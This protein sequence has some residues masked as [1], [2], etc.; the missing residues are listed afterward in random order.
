MF[1]L[2]IFLFQRAF[3]INFF[4]D[5]Y[6]FLKISRASSLNDFVNFFS[7]V[8]GYSYK[9]MATELFYF[10][11]ISLKYR[12]F[13]GHIIVFAVY[14]IGLYYLYRLVRQL[15]KNQ[16]L[17]YLSVFIYGINFIHVYQLYWFATFQ[18]IMV[19]TALTVAFYYFL[20]RKYFLSFIP[21]V[22]ALLSKETAILFVPFLFLFTAVF[23][24][25]DLRKKT[26][27][28][29][30][31]LTIA[32]LFYFVY[33]YSLKQVTALD[34]YKI[35]FDNPK[36]VLNNFLWY[37]LWGLGMPSFMPDVMP[38]IFSKPLPAFNDYFKSQQIQIYF[39]LLGLYWCAVAGMWIYLVVKDRTKL[40]KTL[41]LALGTFAG[42]VIFL[43]PMIFFRH[44]WMIRLTVPL[45]F[46]SL[47]QAYILSFFHNRKLRKILVHVLVVY[48]VLSYFG[49]KIHEST[50]TYLL[51]DNI[52]IKT[53]DYF[54]DNKTRF[55]R[56]PIIYF[57]DSLQDKINPWGGSKKLK[58]SYWDQYFLD[59]YFPGK[60]IRAIYA[61]EQ[62]EPIPQKEC[63]IE[64]DYLLR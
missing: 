14:F 52:F 64:A 16:L 10:L 26:A 59:F 33:R 37:F 2:I 58:N 46:L 60:R 61:F 24:K 57:N 38:S 35:Q 50:S 47:F 23:Q 20:N 15:T 63:I 55:A 13:I 4:L 25:K 11:L 7:P 39:F 9:P 36:L 18:E 1:F 8:R 32:V 5:D 42:F 12:V 27:V 51:E 28:L 54:S 34:N 3:K 31:Y 40:K 41:F 49:I 44:R 19:F 30:F 62:A 56:C 45:V 21:F 17:G 22:I 48:L 43:G 29:F 53:R 6:F